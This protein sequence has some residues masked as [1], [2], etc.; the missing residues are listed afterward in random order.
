MHSADF[1]IVAR[2]KTEALR[3]AKQHLKEGRFS[4]VRGD[5]NDTVD[6]ERVFVLAR[7][8]KDDETLEEI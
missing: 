7:A 1:A 4:D 3:K 8:D 2:N 6:D 5:P